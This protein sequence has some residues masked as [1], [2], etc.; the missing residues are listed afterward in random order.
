MQNSF[1]KKVKTSRQLRRE[2]LFR[3]YGG[4]LMGISAFG[5]KYSRVLVG[6]AFVLF[7]C[8]F[9]YVG[10]YGYAVSASLNAM[11]Y[12]YLI[13]KMRVFCNFVLDCTREVEVD[14]ITFD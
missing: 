2:A 3:K 11:L 12:Y 6:M 8:F 7:T 1:S 5:C 10:S 4:G 14:L 13:S 9:V